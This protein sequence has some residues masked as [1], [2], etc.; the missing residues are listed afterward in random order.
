MPKIMM[1]ASEGSKRDHP[2]GNAKNPRTFAASAMPEIRR[3]NPNSRPARYPK[4]TF[5]LFD[6]CRSFGTRWLVTL[7]S[8]SEAVMKTNCDRDG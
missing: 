5:D 8:N 3:P 1:S 4:I 6:R 2:A 7:A